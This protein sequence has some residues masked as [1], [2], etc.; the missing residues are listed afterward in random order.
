MATSGAAP[1][2]GTWR[3]FVSILG[4]GAVAAEVASLAALVAPHAWVKAP[5]ASAPCPR[6]S[7]GDPHPSAADVETVRRPARLVGVLLVLKHDEGKAGNTPG[8]PDLLN[9]AELG[10]RGLNVPLGGVAVQ[11]CHVE[12]HPI[13]IRGR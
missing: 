3:P 2:P 7:H 6:P 9:W 13:H 8:H 12:P 5:A 4:V 1:V 10:E 11:I